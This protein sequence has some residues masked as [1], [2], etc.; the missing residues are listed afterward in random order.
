MTLR[1]F[2]TYSGLG[3]RTD[4]TKISKQDDE[5]Q[6]VHEKG[7]LGVLKTKEY[8]QQPLKGYTLCIRKLLVCIILVLICFDYQYCCFSG[9]R[10][11]YFR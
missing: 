7:I 11:L 3:N 6:D 1:I 8:K 5:A 10:Y 2:D 4:K 9:T